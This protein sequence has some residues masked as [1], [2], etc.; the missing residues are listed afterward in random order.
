MK[1]PSL[2]LILIIEFVLATLLDDCEGGKFCLYEQEFSNGY[3][4]LPESQSPICQN[5]AQ[6]QFCT[7]VENEVLR[8]FLSPANAEFCPDSYDQKVLLI[9]EELLVDEIE[10]ASTEI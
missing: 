2:I 7:P 3:C 5:Q 9:D 4:C 6:L 1:Y 10:W 8:M